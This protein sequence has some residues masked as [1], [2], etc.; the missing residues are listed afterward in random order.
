M[1]T[2]WV[3]SSPFERRS[4]QAGMRVRAADGTVLGRVA[5]IGR[6][7][8][9]VRPW[10]F[11]R[12]WRAVPLSLLAGLHEGDVYLSGPAPGA[13]EPVLPEVLHA[14]IPTFTHPLAEA[15]GE[16]HVAP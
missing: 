15:S 10:C 5:A 6:D 11:S 12:L 7:S 2:A 16:G 4:I 1:A 13:A 8:L 9:Y 3:D 14:D